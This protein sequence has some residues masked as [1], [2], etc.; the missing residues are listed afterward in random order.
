M[1][2][3]HDREFSKSMPIS[4]RGVGEALFFGTGKRIELQ[5]AH[6]DSRSA[7]TSGMTMLGRARRCIVASRQPPLKTVAGLYSHFAA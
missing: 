4:H 1:P 3:F 5:L 7:R 2:D 6:F